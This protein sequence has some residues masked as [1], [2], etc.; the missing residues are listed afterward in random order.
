MARPQV[1]GV[2]DGLPSRQGVCEHTTD[3]EDKPL[4]QSTDIGGFS[5][6]ENKP[7]L[8]VIFHLHSESRLRVGEAFPLLPHI[9]WQFGAL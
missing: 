1:T 3:S 7:V 5:T 6:W 9:Y 4:S 2:A 8:R